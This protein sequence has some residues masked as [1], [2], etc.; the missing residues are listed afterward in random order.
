MRMALQKTIVVIGATGTMGSAI[1]MALAGNK[2]IELLLMARDQ[3]K[4]KKLADFL[5]KEYPSTSTHT[6]QCSKEACWEADIII[7]AL[8]AEAEAEVADYIKE[9]VTQKI[10][11]SVSPETSLSQLQHVIPYAKIV[12][13]FYANKPQ[14][15]K[16]AIPGKEINSLIMSEDEEALEIVSEL[17]CS[18]GFKPVVQNNTLTKLS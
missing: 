18:A 17:L 12:K 6:V 13:A 8:P 11:I 2:N 15:I 5:K 9:V 10:V 14:E 16:N 4:I 7:M 1:T 3:Q